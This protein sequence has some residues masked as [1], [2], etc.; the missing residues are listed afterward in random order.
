LGGPTSAPLLDI[1]ALTVEYS[2]RPRPSVDGVTFRIDEGEIVGLAGESGCG[3]TSAALA[4]LGLLP[5]S[6]RVGGSIRLRGRELVGLP[7]TA[8]RGIRGREISIVFQEP[9]LAL[10]PVLRVGDQIAE[11]R[12]AH[13]RGTVEEARSHGLRLLRDVGFEADAARIFAAY[14]HQLSG[15]QQ[16][17]AVIA[18]ALACRP[19]LVIADEPCASL[20]ATTQAEILSLVRD[21][22]QRFGTAFLII[23]HDRRVLDSVAGRVIRMSSGRLVDAPAPPVVVQSSRRIAAEETTTLAEVT[24]LSKTYVQWRRF[25]G[26]ATTVAALDN[27]CLTIPKGRTVALVGRSGSGKS[28]LARCLVRLEQPDSGEVRFEGEDLIRLN[29]KALGPYRRRIQLIQQDPTAALNPRFTA[30]EIIEEPLLVQR[31]GTRQARRQRARDLMARV[32]LS[33]RRAGSPPHEFS[34]GERQR[35]AIARALA[36]GP[37]LVVLDEAFSGLDGVTC[38]G[39]IDLLRRLQEEEHLAYLCIAHDLTLVRDIAD[40]VAVLAAGR[41]VERGATSALLDAPQHLAT[42]ALVAASAGG[43]VS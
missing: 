4:V 10:N 9:E 19:S 39:I 7:E 38:A 24:N 28:T 27:V 36:P 3:K 32:G 42:R 16:Q 34:G 41:I 13:H 37:S 1:Q 12:R 30:A 25:G 29:D 5:T 23:S 8:L 11:V 22:N 15:G 14:P 17:R 40:D 31:I 35:L 26:T 6:A 18:Q 20:D 2:L 21:L 43:A 33:P